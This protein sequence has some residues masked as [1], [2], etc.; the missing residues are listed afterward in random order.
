[1]AF[2][3]ATSLAGGFVFEND[4]ATL[5]VGP[6]GR[7]QSLREKATGRELVT[8]KVSFVHLRDTSNRRKIQPKAM[9]GSDRDGWTFSFNE[10]PGEVTISIRSFGPGWIVRV[11]KMTLADAD[12]SEL[13]LARLNPVCD[14]YQGKALPMVS[15]DASGVIVFPCELELGCRADHSEVSAVND[16]RKDVTGLR[17]GVIAGPR[18]AL[19]PALK[20]F[21]EVAKAPISPRGG[22]W[23]LESEE[24]RLSTFFTD[25]TEDSADDWIAYAKR[26]N[27]GIVHFSRWYAGLGTYRINKA[28]FPHGLEGISNVCEKVRAAGLKCGIHTLT[29]CLGVREKTVA[30]F[31]DDLQVYNSYTLARPFGQDD[32]ELVVAEEPD[33][34]HALFLGYSSRGN[35]LRV[36]RELVQYTG[37]RREAPYAFTGLTRAAFG[38]AKAA[39]VVPAG[40]TV[41]YVRQHYMSFYP[42]PHTKLAE[43]IAENVARVFRAGKMDDI[44]HDGAEGIG[45]RYDVDA[46][47]RT[48]YDRLGSAPFMECSSSA[49]PHGW[50]MQSRLGAWDHP[51]WAPKRFHDEHI[52]ML[53]KARKADLMP[54]TTGWWEP[55]KANKESRGHF[56]D[57]MEYFASKNAAHDFCATIHSF[58][59][60][61]GVSTYLQKQIDLFG[62]Y[63]KFRLERAFTPEAL[64]WMRPAVVESRLRRGADGIWRLTSV[65]CCTYRADGPASWMFG[66]AKSGKAALRVEALY[67]A[68]ADA[69]NAVHLTSGAD[70]V[71]YPY[72][73]KS[74]EGNAA[75]ALTVKGT[76]K[77]GVLDVRLRSPHEFAGG[78]SDH[79]VP[80]GFEGTKTVTFLLRERDADRRAREERNVPAYRVFRDAIDLKHLWRIQYFLKDADGAEIGELRAVPV[81]KTRQARPTVTLNGVRHVVPFTLTSGDWAELEDGVWT[82]WSEAGEPL[83]TAPA[84]MPSVVAGENALSY[85][86]ES[87]EGGPAR[88]EVTVTAFGDSIPA[89]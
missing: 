20:K 72:P 74:L 75:F 33:R 36:G 55:R 14:A 18:S 10:I 32:M 4:L 3:A 81:V 87:S 42:R 64:A 47:R 86:A 73:Y 61:K 43:E 50:W 23:A 38:T 48:L 31:V 46:V 13:H 35:V 21:A 41:G 76:G 59:I 22:P 53:E 77:G 51:R 71:E 78:D 67:A 85:A 84:P 27:F 8:N 6:S 30:A 12:Y 57:E 19:I 29:A 49:R 58:D 5:T 89:L 9:T 17:C 82:H 83:G 54:V 28:Y 52:R 34:R 11:E 70:K 65:T 7:V 25:M 26:C 37:I 66:F 45:G 88:A 44:Y 40:S 16:H 62:T 2:L 63:E 68:D 69:T 15:D 80:L 79:Y 1:M 60:R 39:G 24:N 56:L